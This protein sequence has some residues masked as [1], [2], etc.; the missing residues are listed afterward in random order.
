MAVIVHA[1]SPFLAT[2][3]LA[4]AQSH[5]RKRDQ[6]RKDADP[7]H[8]SDTASAV[9]I[10]F[11]GTERNERYSRASAAPRTRRSIR[12][13]RRPLAGSDWSRWVKI[14]LLLSGTALQLKS[15]DES[16]IRHPHPKSVSVADL[17]AVP[18]HWATVVAQP[19][20]SGPGCS[21]PSENDRQ[22]G[23]N[24]L[25]D[26]SDTKPIAEVT[27]ERRPEFLHLFIS[28]CMVLRATRPS[29]RIVPPKIFLLVTKARR[30]FSDALVCKGIWG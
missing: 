17:V 2:G 25:A 29:R 12:A 20:R 19:S 4:Q 7:H 14:A 27:A 8:F 11:I 30:S 13:L 10:D 5:I 26:V 16:D 1:A 3:R 15:G 28:P 22:Q 9:W 21:S 23:R 6:P 18:V 24:R